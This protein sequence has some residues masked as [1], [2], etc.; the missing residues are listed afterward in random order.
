MFPVDDVDVSNTIGNH[1]FKGGELERFISF[2]VN[3]VFY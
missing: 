3:K 2:G 1:G